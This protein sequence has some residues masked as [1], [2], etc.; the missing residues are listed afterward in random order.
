MS[1]FLFLAVAAAAA[2][3][4]VASPPPPPPLVTDGCLLW[5]DGVAP[6]DSAGVLA[7]DRR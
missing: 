7:A 6:R 3:M 2:A 1:A 4:A 5:I